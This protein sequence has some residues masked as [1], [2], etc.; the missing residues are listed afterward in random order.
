IYDYEH[1]GFSLDALSKYLEKKLDS[2]SIQNLKDMRKFYNTYKDE[3]VF[4]DFIKK[5]E[6][7][8]G[9]DLSRIDIRSEFPKSLKQY[10]PS[11]SQIEHFN[12]FTN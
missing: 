11:F 4:V 1:D 12:E 8:E 3:Q 9:R 7:E 5:V 10:L 6:E 2:F